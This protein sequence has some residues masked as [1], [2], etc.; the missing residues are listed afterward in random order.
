MRH[1]IERVRRWAQGVGPV[2][3]ADRPVKHLGAVAGW[4]PATV[5]EEDSDVP[6]T[7]RE[8]AEADAE[9][10]EELNAIERDF[11]AGA[12]AVLDAALRALRLDGR[13][14]LSVVGLGDTAE[15][16]LVTR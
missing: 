15:H 1:L 10:H 6:L 12:Q 11:Q 16:R 9:L 8:L 7:R 5:A 2:L 4:S 3:A 13:G 14:E